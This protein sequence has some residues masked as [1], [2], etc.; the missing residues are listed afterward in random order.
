MKPM[1]A[2]SNDGVPKMR[3][4]GSDEPP[5]PGIPGPVSEQL[6]ADQFGRYALIGIVL[7]VSVA[8]FQMVRP[9]LVP[10]ILAAVF[11]GLSY[12]FYERLLKASHGRKGLS[13]FVCCLALS[14]GLLLP[15]YLLAN[16]VAS[17]V[18]R[19][20]QAAEPKIRTALNG[21]PEQLLLSHSL[22]RT[23][24][25]EKLPLQPAIEKSLRIATEVAGAAINRI[26]RE[27]F[28]LVINFF[29]TF[30]TMFYFF[31]DGPVLL[32]RLKYFSPIARGYEEEMIRRLL[33][34][35]RAT[36]K[37][38]LLVAVL[39]GALG[40][41]TFWLFGIEAPVLWGVTM[42]FLS[43]LPVVG[44]WLVMFPAGL[45]FILSGQTMAG[46][47]LWIIASVVIGSLD[48]LL[49]PFLIGRDSGLHDLLVFFSMLGGIGLF[50]VMG[51]IVG[52]AIAALFRTLLDIYGIEFKRQLD[53]VHQAPRRV[54]RK[55]VF[56]I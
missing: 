24:H 20:Y 33:L 51:F 38:T 12:P 19:I 44:A 18:T 6:G 55:E 23:L 5:T 10:I 26:S 52:P 17:E 8:F 54:E 3:P 30:F 14:L 29:I 28:S 41:L 2:S 45:V 49:E 1:S 32:R 37:G 15:A 56:E 7:L 31:R 22:L 4:T 53:L 21:D 47:A 50:G 9:F 11:T 35:T 40:G 48:N 16:L 34:I 13:A 25:V 39:K 27:T 43:V 36:I 42:T 46:L